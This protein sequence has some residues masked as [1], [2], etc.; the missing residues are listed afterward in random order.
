M[1]K[2]ISIYCSYDN[3]DRASKDEL[4]K[5]LDKSHISE[6]HDREINQSGD[7][8]DHLNSADIILLLISVDFVAS[9]YCY[10]T[11][12]YRALQRHEQGEAIVVPIILR[13]VD[14]EG[15]P[16]SHLDILPAGGRPI[17]RWVDTN[18]AY[19]NAAQGLKRII[20]TIIVKKYASEAA[21]YMVNEKYGDAIAIYNEALQF[22]ENNST[23]YQDMARTYLLLNR[24]GEALLALQQATRLNPESAQLWR[25][26]A[27]VLE[28]LHRNDEAI[29]AYKR[30]IQLDTV[31]PYLYKELGDVFFLLKRWPEALSCY[32]NAIR[33]QPD[34]GTAYLRRSQVYEQIVQEDQKLALAKEN[35]EAAEAL[36]TS[37]EEG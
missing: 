20:N 12:M 32:T 25:E 19:Q 27:H 13:P 30:A 35:A 4:A 14:W 26:T 22:A 21:I 6:W 24:P 33:L 18:E 15:T 36:E 9:D 1:T 23:L 29:E 16:F 28:A 37:Q 11:E 34:L 17:S 10:G 8:D 7:V 31:N 5:H 3:K 2:Y